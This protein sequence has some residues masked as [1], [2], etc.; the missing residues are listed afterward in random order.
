MRFVV[1]AFLTTLSLSP[2]WAEPSCPFGK[3]DRY[4]DGSLLRNSDGTAYLYAMSH[5]QVD[6]DGAPNAYHP[7][8]VGLHCTKGTGFKGLDCPANAGYPNASWWPSA[9][10]PDPANPKRAFVQPSGEFAGF[11]VSQT[12]LKDRAK[13]ATD[14]ARYV[15]SRTIPY[16]V[17][18]GKFFKK[19][20][21][22]GMGDLGY[23]INLQTGE[24]SPFVVAEVGPPNSPLGEISIRLA[25]VLGGKNPNPRTG[26]GTPTGK[27]LYVVF[28]YSGRKYA[29]PQSEADLAQ[30][31]TALLEGTGGAEAVIACASSL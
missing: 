3:W 2:V 31:A 5:A 25:E 22:G 24:K 30:N 18:P 11:F 13:P 26:T 19:K 15:D 21:T 7:D 6:A 14:P 8:D 12:T 28:P 17:F 1:L 23:A 27:I 4:Q 16:I 20:G 29:W 10:L 9:L